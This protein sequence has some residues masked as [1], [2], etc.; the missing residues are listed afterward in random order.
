MSEEIYKIINGYENYE[1]SDLGNVRNVTTNKILK[2]S[3]NSGGYL[4][5][6]LYVNGTKKTKP[7]HSLVAMAFLDNVEYKPLV[8]HINNH[9]QDNR[10]VNL[11]YANSSENGQNSK[12]SSRNTSGFK[13]VS[14]YK[15]T[16]KW[17]A[18]IRIDGI[19]INLGYYKTKEE[20]RDV[21]VQKANEVF[22]VFTNSCEKI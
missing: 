6:G 1:V 22:G 5:V 4:L 20:A 19:L 16:N 7:I 17:L 11:R 3:S 10:L 2:G 21:R 18:T 9:K 13:G 12:L 15:P 8:D 14:F